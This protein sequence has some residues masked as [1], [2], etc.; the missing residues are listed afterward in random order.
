MAYYGPR[1]VHTFSGYEW[2]KAIDHWYK[3]HCINHYSR[4]VTVAQIYFAYYQR[5]N[6]LHDP[7]ET[8][9]QVNHPRACLGTV[10]ISTQEEVQEATFWIVS[11]FA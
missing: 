8:I 9:D 11:L 2:W 3:F 5:T 10:Q 1:N 4:L 7:E 6:W